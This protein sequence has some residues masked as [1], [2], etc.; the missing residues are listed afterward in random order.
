M[1]GEIQ[2]VLFRSAE[3]RKCSQKI[4]VMSVASPWLDDERRGMILSVPA[5]ARFDLAVEL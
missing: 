5:W 2:A 4:V 1:A 3:Q